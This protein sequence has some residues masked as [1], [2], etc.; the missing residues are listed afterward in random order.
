[1]IVEYGHLADMERLQILLEATT[2]MWL[3]ISHE[4][5]N[6]SSMLKDANTQ[7]R[8][9]NRRLDGMKDDMH[10]EL[11]NAMN[12]LAALIGGEKYDISDEEIEIHLR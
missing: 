12:R 11:T 8:N 5:Q 7:R 1:M 10:V 4:L 9:I 2:Q 3:K 6:Q